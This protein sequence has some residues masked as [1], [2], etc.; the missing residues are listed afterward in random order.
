MPVYERET[1][2]DAPFA[3]VWDFHSRVTGLEDLTP[4]WMHLRVESIVGPDGAQFDDRQAVLVEGS[5]IHSTVRPLG[6][7]PAQRWTSVIVDREESEGRGLF[8]DEMAE[9][10][11]PHWLHTHTIEAV[12]GGTR[13]H[14]HVEYELPLGAL[15][16]AVAPLGFIGFAPMFRHRH[17]ETKRLLE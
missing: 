16:R 17:R 14:D 7:A 11:F 2:V 9:G 5:K 15:G 1:V 3:D 4:D 13:V 12:D 8:R 6:V 10:P